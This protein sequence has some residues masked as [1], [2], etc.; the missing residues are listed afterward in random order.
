[1]NNLNKKIIE[2]CDRLYKSCS[3]KKKIQLIPPPYWT[4][5]IYGFGKEISRYGYYPRALPLCINTDH[6][7]GP[8]E[9][10]LASELQTDAPVQMFHSPDRLAAWKIQTKK[11]AWVLYS[12]FVFFK[13]RN[14]LAIQESAAGTVAFAA[15]ST[16]SID[17]ISGYNDYIKQLNLLPDKFK[18]ITVCMHC[19]DVDKG[20]HNIFLMAGFNVVTAGNPMD[21]AFIK[22]FYEILLK[23]KY[24]TSSVPGSYAYYSVEAEIP[25]FI[26][27]TKP[28]WENKGDSNYKLGKFDPYSSGVLK[29]LYDLFC[30]DINQ[31]KTPIIS[32]EQKNYVNYHLGLYDGVSRNKMALILYSSIIRYVL[33]KSGFLYIIKKNLISRAV[34]KYINLA[35]AANPCN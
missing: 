22:N 31:N 3:K 24:S 35:R 17:D 14:A 32:A 25:F 27:G 8:R 34:K 16:S 10:V 20:L 2:D 4:A 9:G 26:H 6:A 19:H 29:D 11:R 33:T 12:P 18:P 7:P 23:H 28:N 5:E 21:E 30:C 13:K 1:M 15:H